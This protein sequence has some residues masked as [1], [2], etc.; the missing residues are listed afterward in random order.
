MVG[1]INIYVGLLA[2]ITKPMGMY[3]MQ[4]L[5]TNGRTCLTRSEAAERVTTVMG[6]KATG[7]R[8][9]ALHA[10]YAVIQPGE[11][12]FSPMRFCGCNIRYRSIRKAWARSA[13]T[14]PST[15]RS[16]LRRT[17]IGRAMA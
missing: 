9:E 14:L 10:G 1:C 6:V 12:A 15:L 13:R 8:L 4:V 17:P 3:L 2:L 5:D 11:F 7:T 16:V